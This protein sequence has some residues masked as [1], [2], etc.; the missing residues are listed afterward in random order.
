M[1]DIRKFA[2]KKFGKMDIIVSLY[3]MQIAWAGKKFADLVDYEQKDLPG[4]NVRDII[5]IDYKTIARTIGKF[6]GRT[7][8]D[9]RRLRRRDGKEIEIAGIVHHFSYDNEDYI[10]V[11]IKKSRKLK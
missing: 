11:E 2:E 3:T 8:E 6:L 10:T 9:T 5:I 4:M 7:S 1:D